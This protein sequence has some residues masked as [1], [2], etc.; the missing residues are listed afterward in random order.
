MKVCATCKQEL[1]DSQFRM[2]SKGHLLGSCKKCRVE[3][4]AKRRK[5]IDATIEYKKRA[6]GRPRKFFDLDKI[7]EGVMK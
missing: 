6:P 3:K 7:F 5:Y 4:N 2:D 1:D